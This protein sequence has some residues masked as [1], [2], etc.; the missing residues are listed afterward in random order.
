MDGGTVIN[1]HFLPESFAGVHEACVICALFLIE[2]MILQVL[3]VE[4]QRV[5]E[6]VIGHRAVLGGGRFADKS[7]LQIRNFEQLDQLFLKGC[8]LVGS[9]V[10]FEPEEDIV[11]HKMR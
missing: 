5:I 2:L 8:V 6:G 10:F 7:V 11:D 1:D 4:G 3:E 9:E